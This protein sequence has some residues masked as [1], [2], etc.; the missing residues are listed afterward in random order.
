M[1]YGILFDERINVETGTTLSESGILKYR[2]FAV[3]YDIKLG[4]EGRYGVLIEY[5]MNEANLF[6]ATNLLTPSNHL[7]LPDWDVQKNWDQTETRH[8]FTVPLWGTQ[9]DFC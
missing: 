4:G 7:Q 5:N 1:K 3:D 8:L 6:D 2:D 9:P